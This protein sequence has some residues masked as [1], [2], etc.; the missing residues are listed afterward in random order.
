MN[1]QQTNAKTVNQI[2]RERHSKYWVDN[3]PCSDWG[4]ILKWVDLFTIFA[5]PGYEPGVVEI[6]KKGEVGKEE[7]Y[8]YIQSKVGGVLVYEKQ[9]GSVHYI[10]E[11]QMTICA[12][13]KQA[14]FDCTEGEIDT[15]EKMQ[16]IFAIADSYL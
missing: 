12:S 2:F 8:I 1:T 16:H 3:Y 4:P 9:D 10:C 7:N 14:G 5:K 6:G 13:F 15:V 11:E